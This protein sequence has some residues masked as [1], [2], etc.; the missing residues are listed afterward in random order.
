MSPRRWRSGFLSLTGALFLGMSIPA[1]PCPAS[2]GG[3]TTYTIGGT[4]VR[5]YNL[6]GTLAVV[7]GG[8]PA[9]V[10]EVTLKGK[11]AAQLKVETGPIDG[12]QTLRVI[13][14]G[15]RI[16]LP[17]FGDQSTSTFRVEPEGTFHDE[18]HGGRR[19]VISGQGP[20][21]EAGADIRLLVPPG[22]KVGIY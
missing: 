14:P 13:Y 8:G 17:G 19:V 3:P 4:D 7:R 6:V 12:R 11:D 5:I 9:V 16:V 22:K 10:A 2:P 21:V 15:N 1:T 20:G 18:Q